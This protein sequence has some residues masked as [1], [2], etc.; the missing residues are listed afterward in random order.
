MPADPLLFEA[1][2][3]A[4][5]SLGRRGAVV[6]SGLVLLASA[7][8]ATLVLVLGGWPVVGFAT[9]EVALAL[10]LLTLHRRR[11]ARRCE[12]VR[13]TSER[14]IICRTDARGRSEEAALDPYWA[15][16]SLQARPG[17]VSLL[18][19]QQRN[20]AFEIG[21]LL[22]EEAKRDLATALDD[23]LRRLREPRFDNPQL[24]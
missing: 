11:A 4:P 7:A 21:R 19:L 22:G 23:A 15:R 13:L 3:T 6:L 8:V 17:R 14:L 16:L 2:C 1:I 18:V 10:G 24:R 20:R 5:T 9:V 12:I